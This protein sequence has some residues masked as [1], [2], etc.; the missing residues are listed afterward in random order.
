MGFTI[1]KAKKE[2]MAEVFQLIKELAIFE[3]EPDAVQITIADL[4]N[5]GFGDSPQFECFVGEINSRIEGIALFYNRYSTWKGRALHLEDLIVRENKRGTGLGTALLDEVV[6][7]GHQLGVK[8]INWEVLDWNEPAI[9]FYEK[10]GAK[11]MRDWD[12][13]QLSEQ[14]IKDYFSKL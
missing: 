7:Y 5:D 14:G 11:V 1:R 3:K 6:K 2:D 12:V 10:K 8:R 9:T 4:E 13:V